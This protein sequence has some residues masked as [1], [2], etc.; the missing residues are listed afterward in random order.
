MRRYIALFVIL[1]LLACA[2]PALAENATTIVQELTITQENFHVTGSSSLYGYLYLKLEN[3]GNTPIRID[4]GEMEIL[5]AEG[6]PLASTTTLWRYAEYLK[7]GESTY[8][9][10]SQRIDGIESADEAASYTRSVSFK[11]TKDRESFR[12]PVESVF[13]D[14]VQEGSWTRDYM[15]TTVTND[16]DQTVFDVSV[17]RALLDGAGNI[18]YI[19]SDSMYNYKGITSGSSIVLRRSLSSTNTDYFA[20]KGYAPVTVDAIAYANVADASVF[21][22]SGTGAAAEEPEVTAEATVEPEGKA[23]APE[24][25]EAPEVVY[26]TLQKGSKGKAVKKLQKRLKTL[27]YLTGKVDGDY[28]KGTAKAVKAFQKKAGLPQTGVADDAT[29]KALYADDAPAA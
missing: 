28:G 27:G 14:D 29:Q 20:E 1:A 19:D 11:A 6:E 8:A 7:P 23:D 5:N 17:V 4:G 22:R 9:Y 15:T 25:T 24:Q 21:T 2:L 26:E 18:L 13:E 12:L 16:T 10:F 3:T